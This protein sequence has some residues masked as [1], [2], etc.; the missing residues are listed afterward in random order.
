M[1]IRIQNVGIV[2]VKGRIGGHR[3]NT[4]RIYID[5]DT[6]HTVSRRRFVIG[7]LQL[8]FQFMLDIQIQRGNDIVPV[9]RFHIAFVVEGHISVVGVL[10]FYVSAGGS[11][12]DVVVLGFQSVDAHAVRIGKAKHM[13]GQGVVGIIPFRGSTKVDLTGESVF[14]DKLPYPIRVRFL[15]IL[16]DHF[17]AA[18]I[19][20]GLLDDGGVIHTEDFRQL[21]G[22]QFIHF[23]IGIGSAVRRRPCIGGLEIGG[24]LLPLCRCFHCGRFRLRHGIDNVLG[25]NEDQIHRCVGGQDVAVAIVDDAPL[26]IDL[27][28]VGQLIDHFF[29]I[30]IVF[31]D[32]QPEQGKNQNERH[33]KKS[34]HD[35][36]RS[37][38]R[39]PV[40]PLGG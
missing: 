20:G 17:V 31:Q 28:F 11:L 30:V 1:G 29:L 6:G 12:Q 8:V 37:H 33:R 40:D 3:Q 19:L 18:S 39:L 34:G 13:A 21:V 5:H 38:N 25:R 27:R 16:F 32:L 7:G 10:R 14:C 26:R 22:D 23:D 2:Q 9:F 35:N 36:Q 4:A 24:N 15:H